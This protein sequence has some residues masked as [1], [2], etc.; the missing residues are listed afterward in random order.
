MH[1]NLLRLLAVVCRPDLQPQQMMASTVFKTAQLA[2]ETS[3]GETSNLASG[4]SRYVR[5]VE[6]TILQQ[7]PAC[8]RMLRMLQPQ[9][10]MAKTVRVVF[11]PSRSLTS[12][13][14]PAR[15]PKGVQTVE[16]LASNPT[17]RD[18]G[19]PRHLRRTLRQR[20]SELAHHTLWTYSFFQHFCSVG[21]KSFTL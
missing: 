21:S 13:L 1:R 8:A 7:K 16:R 9:Q 3:P 20:R 2:S 11:R 19:R 14:L 12:G 5:I 17:S 15:I 18:A 10:A 4:A 6:P